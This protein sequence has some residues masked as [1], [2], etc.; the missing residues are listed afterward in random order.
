MFTIVE[1]RQIDQVNDTDEKP[2]VVPRGDSSRLK[3]SMR[4]SLKRDLLTKLLINLSI[5][6]D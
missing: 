2:F 5:K 4:V 6:L 3:I 1:V